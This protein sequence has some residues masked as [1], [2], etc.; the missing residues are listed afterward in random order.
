MG[1]S[2]NIG[3]PIQQATNLLNKGTGLLLGKPSASNDFNLAAKSAEDELN[4]KIEEQE[5]L[6]KKRI[7][8]LRSLFTTTPVGLPNS[9]NDLNP[10]SRF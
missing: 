8:N 10:F 6:R 1:G 2:Y 5:A 3:N 9:F 7:Q 4:L